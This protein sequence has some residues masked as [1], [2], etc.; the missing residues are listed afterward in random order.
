MQNLSTVNDVYGYD[1]AYKADGTGFSYNAAYTST[2]AYR[3]E[4][5]EAAG[6]NG[7]DNPNRSDTLSFTYTGD[8]VDLY[9]SCGEN[10][11][12]YIITIKNAETG[13][14]EKV[15]ILDTYFSDSTYYSDGEKINQVPILHHENS[16]RGTYK[17]E[18]TSA[19]LSSVVGKR[20]AA[21]M[22]VFSD[23]EINFYTTDITEQA[24]E[25]ILVMAEMEDLLEEDIE[26]VFCDENS[27]L[28]V[29][30]PKGS[31]VE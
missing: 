23:D 16:L 2:V 5:L 4:Y 10:T 25:A 30:L 7:V 24:K 9:G 3:S 21:T 31:E 27:V 1:T 13:S 11:G 29:I 8:A 12:I 28:S 14:V 20:N 26:V 17:V 15:Y 6:L 19:Y 22:S 18:I